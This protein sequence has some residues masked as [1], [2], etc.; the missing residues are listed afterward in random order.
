[1]FFVSS[2]FIYSVDSQT[3][4]SFAYA[5]QQATTSTTDESQSIGLYANQRFSK[6]WSGSAYL[7]SGLTDSVTDTGNGLFLINHF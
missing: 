7:N 2:G 5:Y 4:F 3:S 6:Q 1:M